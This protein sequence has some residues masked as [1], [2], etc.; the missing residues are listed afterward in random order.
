MT[1]AEYVAA[2]TLLDRATELM[3]RRETAARA[4]FLYDLRQLLVAFDL[5]RVGLAH[6]PPELQLN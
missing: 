6:P 3:R 2:L 5:L 1:H 4:D